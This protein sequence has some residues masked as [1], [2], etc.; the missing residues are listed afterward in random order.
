MAQVPAEISLTAFSPLPWASVFLPRGRWRLVAYIADAFGA[1]TRAEV[2]SAAVTVTAAV[3]CSADTGGLALALANGLLDEHVQRIVALAGFGD[4]SCA[5]LTSVLLDQIRAAAG[6]TL[7][8]E[9]RQI[10]LAGAL[11]AVANS[12]VS[13]SQA[14]P[15]ALLDGVLS[16]FESVVVAAGPAP[17]VDSRKLGM[18]ATP[19][20]A[21]SGQDLQ[22]SDETFAALMLG[23]L[24]PVVGAAV[25]A[26]NA[27][28]TCARFLRLVP[29][30]E[31][32]AARLQTNR[33]V[34]EEPSSVASPNIVLS[35]QRFNGQQPAAFA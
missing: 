35:A 1:T 30:A 12:A 14:P 5:Q 29:L 28:A 31:R 16:A 9:R 4:G 26:E 27:S 20:S 13:A 7:Q 10:Q 34:A 22:S 18:R 15:A 19:S 3:N 17:F 21:G 11:W 25:A 8:D 33:I 24:S 2:A 32:L 23:V 6:A